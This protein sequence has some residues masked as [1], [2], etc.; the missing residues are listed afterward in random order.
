MATRIQQR[1]GT[2]AEL[3]SVVLAI[4]EIG[5]DTES[6]IIKIGDGEN[7]WADLP[8]ISGPQGP[9]GPIGPTGPTGPSV[10]GPTGST[11]AIGGEVAITGPTAPTPAVAGELWLNTSNDIVYVYRDSDWQI[12]INIEPPLASTFLL[13]GA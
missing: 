2:S 12:F 9:T 4:G 13:M 5:F 7:T 8:A 11:G 1:R 10:T 6:N 3:A